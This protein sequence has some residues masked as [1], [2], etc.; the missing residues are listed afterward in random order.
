MGKRYPNPRIVKIHYS[1]TVEEVAERLSKHKNTIR[2]WIKEGLLTI[3]NKRPT[4]IQGQDLFDFLKSKREQNKQHCK[5]G[6]LY[7][8][9]CR[10]PRIPVDSW[11]EY[12]P[13]TEDTGNLK[14]FC[15]VCESIMN[16][17]VSKPKIPKIRGN[18]AVTFPV[19][20]RHIVEMDKP[21]V[22]CYL[23]Q[24]E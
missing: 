6:E 8:V 5:P 7:C 22:N 3:D 9:R 12:S 20:M 2:N 14:G 23:G 24:G 16:R 21:S 13:V 10:Q 1:Y 4:L 18:L 19:G 15:P 17:R 11:V